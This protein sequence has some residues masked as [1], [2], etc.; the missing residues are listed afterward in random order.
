MF[1]GFQHGVLTRAHRE[2]FSGGNLVGIL[3]RIFEFIVY[4]LV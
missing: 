1:F 2:N 3:H 4:K